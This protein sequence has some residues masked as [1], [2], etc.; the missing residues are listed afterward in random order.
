MPKTLVLAIVLVATSSLFAQSLT[1]KIDVSLVNVDVSVTSHGAP[2]RGLTRDD[3]QVFEDGVARPI[4]NFYAV[5]PAATTASHA[6]SSPTPDATATLADPTDE[7]FR[8]K[9]LVI[10]DNRH[11]TMHNRDRALAALERFVDDRFTGG[12]YDWSIALVSDKVHLMLP[13]TSDKEKLHEAVGMVRRIVAHPD[14]P[15]DE[16]VTRLISLSGGFD[17][18]NDSSVTSIKPGAAPGESLRSLVDA[19]NN[20]Q[21]QADATKTVES[22]RDAVRS[23][24]GA[25]GRK[26]ILLVTG[27]LGLDDY[28]SPLDANPGSFVIGP[29][30]AAANSRFATV[31]RDILIR[32]ANASNVS[33]FIINSEGLAPDS[34]ASDGSNGLGLGSSIGRSMGTGNTNSLSSMYWLARETGGRLMSGNSPVSSLADFDRTSSSFYSLAYKPAH[35]DDGKYHTIKVRM[36]RSGYQLQYRT[37]YSSIPATVQLARAMDS[38]LGAS[39]QQSSIPI[40]IVTGSSAPQDGGVL[41]PLH[42]TVAAKN[43]QFIPTANGS[44]ARVDLYVSVFDDRG[45][46]VTGTHYTREAHATNGTESDGNFV[47]TRQLLIRK[48]IPYR[49]VVGVHDQVTDA[50]GIASQTVR[51]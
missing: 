18:S 11:V 41:V 9:V 34:D 43:L 21:I 48:G 10:I 16:D 25:P 31:M 44:V 8:R 7:R 45:R 42:A 35:G 47:E 37:G 17:A 40:N 15:T 20:F 27:S 2:A 24:A 51:F 26:I 32:E 14:R 50:I 5:E 33:F 22:I 29:A 1:E 30:E 23:F 13:L 6:T 39:M 3:F 28:I 19:G 38:P 4:T 46:K 36:N 49:V 12:T